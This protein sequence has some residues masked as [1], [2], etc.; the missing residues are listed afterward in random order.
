LTD[1]SRLDFTEH[2]TIDSFGG[3]G[4][5]RPEEAGTTTRGS[6]ARLE[7]PLAP[8]LSGADLVL[9]LDLHA[10]TGTTVVD[11]RANGRRL[12]RVTVWPERTSV[13][14]VVPAATA[15]RAPTLELSFVRPATL[16]L[17]RRRS[18]ALRIESLALARG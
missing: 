4:W 10:R 15:A 11:V 16:P 7:L 12:D 2:S 14:I 18:L 13:S 5:G 1:G 3:S 8:E 17:G 6:E 9:A